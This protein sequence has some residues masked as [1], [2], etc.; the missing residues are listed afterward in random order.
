MCMQTKIEK[1][2]SLKIVRVVVFLIETVLNM[3]IALTSGLFLSMIIRGFIE[4]NS[5]LQQYSLEFLFIVNIIVICVF[6]LF[7]SRPIIPILV[8]VLGWVVL[9][10]ITT[11]KTS[12]W[13]IALVTLMTGL[14]ISFLISTSRNIYA[15]IR[16]KRYYLW[17]FVM[18]FW[19]FLAINSSYYTPFWSNPFFARNYAEMISTDYGHSLALAPPGPGFPSF[20]LLAKNNQGFQWNITIPFSTVEET[21]AYLSNDGRHIKKTEQNFWR[22]MTESDLSLFTAPEIAIV[23]K[24]KYDLE[25]GEITPQDVLPTGGLKYYMF[26]LSDAKPCNSYNASGDSSM[27]NAYASFLEDENGLI[28]SYKTFASIFQSDLQTFRCVRDL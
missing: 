21:C 27:C 13:T 17:G 28:T 2:F 7:R 20:K 8:A 3:F 18:C 14:L 10:Q 4:R 9:I 22:I 25:S 23:E 11:E 12:F 6:F 1:F 16:K 24:G 5:S 26:W 19:A 15:Q